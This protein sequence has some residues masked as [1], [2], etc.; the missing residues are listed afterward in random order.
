MTTAK[1][2]FVDRCRAHGAN[3]GT[4]YK[5]ALDLSRLVEMAGAHPSLAA[6]LGGA[7]I[8]GA[9]GALAGGKNRARNAFLGA[10]IGGGAGVAG[11]AGAAHMGRHPAP[12]FVLPNMSTVDAKTKSEIAAPA[13]EAARKTMSPAATSQSTEGSAANSPAPAEA[14]ATDAGPI[15]ARLLMA[16]GGLT[17]KVTP[18]AQAPLG[19][20]GSEHPGNFEPPHIGAVSNRFDAGGIKYHDASRL[21]P[22]GIYSGQPVM[23]NPSQ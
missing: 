13:L 7:A 9:A 4:M 19:Q 2:G 1:Q 15:E 5:Y 14:R 11:A 8:G 3:P 21:V 6:G 12:P 17:N 22:R 20:Y 23:S 16:M 18:S 10:L